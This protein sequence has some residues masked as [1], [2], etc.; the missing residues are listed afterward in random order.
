MRNFSLAAYMMAGV[1]LTGCAQ[2]RVTERHFLRPDAPGTVIEK[3]FASAA[4]T[5]L[6]IARPNGAT[7]N[8]IL[9]EQP[10]AR[11]TVLYFG[12][13]MF[14]LDRHIEHVLPVLGACGTNVAVFDYRGYGRST[15]KPTVE[16]MQAD[17]L[18]IFDALNT[19]FPGRV[20]VHGQSLGSFM[21]AYVAQE[22]PVLAT[23]LETT[24][25]SPQELAQSSV[26][27][28]AWP[29][30]RIEVDSALRQV[31]MRRAAPRFQAP[32]L[33]IAAGRDKMTPPKLGRKVFDAIPRKD[34][35]WLLLPE[36]EHNNALQSNGAG[37]AYCGFVRGV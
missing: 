35:Q 30:V 29:F 17:A 14:H 4:A 27:W 5:D 18:A 28:Y 20:I 36:A 6:A 3:R 7:L 23:V 2:I 33:V 1:V 34:K 15:G 12:G 8:G 32:T 22:K 10:G 31:D 19:R 21:A 24:V 25:T 16:T 9:F 11:S 37:A 26:P 13:N